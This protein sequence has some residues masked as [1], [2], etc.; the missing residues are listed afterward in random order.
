MDPF[1]PPFNRLVIISNITESLRLKKK[2]ITGTINFVQLFFK[3]FFWKKST[4][5]RKTIIGLSE[6]ITPLIP[7]IVINERWKWYSTSKIARIFTQTLMRCFKTISFNICPVIFN[8]FG[9]RSNS[10]VS[11]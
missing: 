5:E 1:Y 11:E 10:T 6:I 9:F 4:E 2:K 3:K 7:D 8:G